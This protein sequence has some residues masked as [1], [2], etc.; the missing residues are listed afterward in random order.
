[1][2]QGINC[3]C[4]TRDFA[5]TRLHSSILLGNTGQ[6]PHGLP[7]S[8]FCWHGGA[9]PSPRG[10]ELWELRP[11]GAQILGLPTPGECPL[12][13]SPRPVILVAALIL[14][15]VW[16]ADIRRLWRPGR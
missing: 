14:R 7:L 9:V 13:P 12:N 15:R 8:V 10:H 16:S 3:D 11:R 2:P 1:M 4:S 6:R 5:L